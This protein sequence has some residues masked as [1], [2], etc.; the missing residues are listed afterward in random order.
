MLKFRPRKS[1]TTVNGRFYDYHP[2]LKECVLTDTP[3]HLIKA[4]LV[5]VLMERVLRIKL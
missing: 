2:F 5:E 1:T 3:G 4:S